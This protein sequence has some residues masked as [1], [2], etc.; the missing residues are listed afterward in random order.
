MDKK[1]VLKG[2]VGVV[3]CFFMVLSLM[4]FANVTKY[5]QSDPQQPTTQ[6]TQVQAG[7]VAPADEEKID[8]FAVRKEDNFYQAVNADYLTNTQIPAL[9]VEIGPLNGDMANEVQS[10]LIND[11]EAMLKDGVPKEVSYME[12]PVKLYE[13]LKDNDAINKAGAEPLREKF[14]MVE[15]IKGKK[16]FQEK[17]PELLVWGIPS[18]INVLVLPDTTD[19]SRKVLWLD[20]PKL[21]FDAP[22]FYME[23]NEAGEAFLP[24]MVEGMAGTLEQCGYSQQESEKMASGYIAMEKLLAKYMMLQNDTN[25]AE[26]DDTTETSNDGKVDLKKFAE[27]INSV[28]LQSVLEGLVGKQPEKIVVG[29]PVYYENIDNIITAD[30]LEDMKAWMI[31]KT[32]YDNLAVLGVDLIKPLKSA[33]MSANGMSE[34]SAPPEAKEDKEERL[35]NAI[36]TKAFLGVTEVYGPIIGYYYGTS[37]VDENERDYIIQM[38]EEMQAAYREDLMKN[39]WLSDETIA[40]AIKKLDNM[41]F[42]VGYPDKMPSFVDITKTDQNSALEYMTHIKKQKKLAL[43]GNLDRSRDFSDLDE[44]GISMHV[45]NASYVLT[46]N[47]FFV[48]AG[49]M[50]DPMF[51]IEK[52]DSYNYGALGNIIGHEISHAFDSDGSNYDEE[53]NFKNWWEDS[54]RVEFDKR[55]QAM[56]ELFDGIPYYNGVVDGDLTL[57]EN[58]ADAGGLKVALSTLKAKKGYDLQE[59]FT[60]RASVWKHKRTP[61]AESNALLTDIHAPAELRVNIQSSNSDDFYEAFR[62]AETDGM[63]LAPKERVAVW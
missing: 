52:S 17:L 54:D 12:S 62:I 14:E 29:A 50:N 63:Y 35:Q 45:V 6:K 36:R 46:S 18:P 41:D 8:Y 3:L 16:D 42:V 23:G 39:D 7:S 25:M 55:T 56:A 38:C 40:R 57:A 33:I 32:I 24:M 30:N 34:D 4:G 47:T 1:R 11:F 13:M 61:Q 2:V 10:R 60:T 43:F 19:V 48:Y 58:I 22:A 49:I 9:A 20:V 44:I 26:S 28:D 59:F 15:S 27:S 51:N 31:C 37:Y 5:S 21:T 53:G